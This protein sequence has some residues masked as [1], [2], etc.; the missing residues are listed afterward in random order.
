MQEYWFKK[1]MRMGS[2]ADPEAVAPRRPHR[3]GTTR[4]RELDLSKE[5]RALPSELVR[6]AHASDSR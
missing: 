6:P 5:E 3:G 2:F 1:G 4:P